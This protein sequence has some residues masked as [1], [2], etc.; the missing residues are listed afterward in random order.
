[1][2]RGMMVCSPPMQEQDRVVLRGVELA[3]RDVRH[4]QVADRPAVLEVE[5]AQVYQLVLRLTGPVRKSRYSVNCKHIEKYSAQPASQRS[6]DEPH[7][8][9]LHLCSL[10]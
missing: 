2:V 7:I 5:I 9:S 10:V 4:V 8:A 3:V 6:D 1:M